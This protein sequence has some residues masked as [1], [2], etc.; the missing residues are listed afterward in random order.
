MQKDHGFQP[1]GFTT[2]KP[3]NEEKMAKF[4]IP[5]SSLL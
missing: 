3:N 4:D 2:F 1:H 5:L